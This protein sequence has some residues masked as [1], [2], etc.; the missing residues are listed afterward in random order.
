[1]RKSEKR[2]AVTRRRFF[3]IAAAATGVA[4]ISPLA[5]KSTFGAAPAVLRGTRIHV[6]RHA[7]FLK[8]DDDWFEAI[9]QKWAQPNGV[10]LVIENVNPNDLVPKISAALMAGAG[11]DLVMLQYNTPHQFDAKLRDVSNIAEKVGKEGGGYFEVSKAYSFTASAQWKAVPW[12]FATNAIVYRTDWLAGVGETKFPGTFE[13]ANRV[14][15]LIKGKYNAPWGQAWSHSFGDPPNIAYPLMWAYGGAEVD[16]SG[17]KVVINSPETITAVEFGVKWFRE[18]MT[19]DML[20]WDD[21][22]NNRAYLAGGCWA[23]NNGATIYIVAKREFPDIAKASD[24]ALNPK[25]PKGLFHLGNGGGFGI[26]TYV[27]D[28]KPVEELLLWMNEEKQYSSFMDVT[29]GWISAPVKKYQDH[30]VWAKDPKMTLF[31]DISIYRWVGWPGPPSLASSEAHSKSVVVDM[32]AKAM[33]GMAPKDA[34]GWAEGELKR[35]YE[36]V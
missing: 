1:M 14:S 35:I 32:F 29:E 24:H 12:Y 7:S 28:P 22:S 36:K 19:P 20:G 26:P 31:K 6:L 27:K 25:G 3:Q 34:V 9:K 5:L 30:P 2:N 4:A 23:T 16:R 15:K 8:D 21:T 11:P 13:E 33:Q 17:K 18:S 10:T